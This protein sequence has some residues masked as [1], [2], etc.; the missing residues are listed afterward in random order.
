MGKYFKIGGLV[1]L[2][3]LIVMQAIRPSKNISTAPQPN[4]IA[5]VLPVDAETDK[6]LRTACYDCHSN[7]TKYPWYAEIMPIGYLVSNHVNGGKRKFNFDEFATY[8]QKQDKADHKLHEISESIE[9]GYMPER[10][11]QWLH[12]EAKL[13]DTDKQRIYNWVQQSRKILRDTTK[14]QRR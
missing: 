14:I 5:N 12:K 2:G 3:L 7:N 8:L 11:Y 9:S 6:L 1:L 13:K 10:S 4:N